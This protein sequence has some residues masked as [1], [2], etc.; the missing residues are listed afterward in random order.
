MTRITTHVLDTSAGHPAAGVAITLEL[1]SGM[2]WK[3][4]A[5]ATTDQDGR[6]P[7]LS[8]KTDHPAGTYRLRFAVGDYFAARKVSTLYPHVEVTFIVKAGEH[9]HVPLLVSPFGYSTYRGS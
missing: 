2:S 8:E 3:A 1:Q 6:A 9:Y 7:A 4:V 5:G